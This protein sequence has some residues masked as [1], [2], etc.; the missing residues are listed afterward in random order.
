MTPNL[1]VGPYYLIDAIGNMPVRLFFASLS[2]PANRRAK[3][4]CICHGIGGALFA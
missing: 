1:L 3:G 4:N 2:S